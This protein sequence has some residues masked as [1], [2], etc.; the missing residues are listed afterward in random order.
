M[1]N[2]N[3][4]YSAGICP[5]FL[6]RFY[7]TGSGKEDS[8]EFGEKRYVFGIS[9]AAAIYRR[10]AR[11]SIKQGKEYFDEDFFHLFDDVDVSWRM[12]K[13][14]GILSIPRMQNASM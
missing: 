3:T 5:S 14:A 12:Q 13:K 6:W 2:A 9:A 11:E 4:I 8:L 1:A 10:E 7:D